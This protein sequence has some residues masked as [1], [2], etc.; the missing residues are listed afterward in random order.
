M[1]K[2][3]GAII[4]ADPNYYILIALG[5]LGV[6]LGFVFRNTPLEEIGDWLAMCSGT[7]LIARAYY[8]E[9]R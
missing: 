6:V 9:P 5:L 1:I 7:W 4:K 8:T 3:I 2:T